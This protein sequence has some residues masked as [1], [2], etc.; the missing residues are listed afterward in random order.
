MI[1]ARDKVIKVFFRG[2]PMNPR[3]PRLENFVEFEPFSVFVIQKR[4]RN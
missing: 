4:N 2:I 1:D 3:Y